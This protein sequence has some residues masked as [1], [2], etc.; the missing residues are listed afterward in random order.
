MAFD[1]GLILVAIAVVVMPRSER[2]FTRVTALVIALA[3]ARAFA[4]ASF[5]AWRN[6]Q[7]RQS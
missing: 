5:Q 2:W 1:A 3:F 7:P 6:R 4:W